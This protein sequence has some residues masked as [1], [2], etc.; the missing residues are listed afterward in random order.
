MNE[1]FVIKSAVELGQIAA[2]L[3]ELLACFSTCTHEAVT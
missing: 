3:S 1:M 2:Q